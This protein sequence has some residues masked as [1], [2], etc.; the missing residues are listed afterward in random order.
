MH[1]F[2]PRIVNPLLTQTAV[3]YRG[4]SLSGRL[5]VLLL[6]GPPRGRALPPGGALVHP[7]FQAHRLHTPVTGL[8]KYAQY[9]KQILTLNL[10]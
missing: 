4:E 6:N 8:R 9:A 5:G 7:G 1:P 10:I 2:P 3:D